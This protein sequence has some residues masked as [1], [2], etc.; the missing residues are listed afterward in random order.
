MGFAKVLMS[1]GRCRWKATTLRI[2]ALLAADAA[3]AEFESEK[4]EVCLMPERTNDA[5]DINTG[6]NF[7]IFE[8]DEG[9]MRMRNASSASATVPIVPTTLLLTLFY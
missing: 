4:D 2:L 3:L 1:D 5:F 6:R 7:I 9:G 8:R